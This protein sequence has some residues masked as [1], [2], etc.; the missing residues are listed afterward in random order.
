MGVY[1]PPI[2]IGFSADIK[3]AAYAAVAAALDAYN[4]VT[5]NTGFPIAY[6]HL[7]ALQRGRSLG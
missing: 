1:K 6:G 4:V 3:A 2:D 5:L 7:S